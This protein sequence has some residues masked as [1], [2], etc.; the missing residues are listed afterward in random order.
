MYFC[1]VH[2]VLEEFEFSVECFF[3]AD[4]LVGPSSSRT[5]VSYVLY[6]H[7]VKS[8]KDNFLAELNKFC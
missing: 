4:Y 6:L 5:M 8:S 2:I 1:P 3:P 7:Y